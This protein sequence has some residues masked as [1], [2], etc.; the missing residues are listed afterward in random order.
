[1]K[2]TTQ[3][4]IVLLGTAFILACSQD[5]PEP[6][7][8]LRPSIQVISPK[9]ND[10]LQT[11]EQLILKAIFEDDQ[12]LGVYKIN[13]HENGDDHSHSRRSASPFSLEKTFELKG[14]R[15]EVSD[16]LAIPEDAEHGEY[17]LTIEAIDRAGNA[18][19]FA[20]GSSKQITIFIHGEE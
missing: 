12:E 13:I 19:N 1:M 10:S 16:T 4:A 20:D 3:L 14:R 15:A 2:Y 7:D 9:T 8:T 18:T 17:H 11:G 6:V 5:S